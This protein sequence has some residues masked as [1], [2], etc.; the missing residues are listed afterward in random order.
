LG[1]VLAVVSGLVFRRTLFAQ[2]HDSLFVLE[3]PPY[4]MPTLRGLVT[5][6]WRHSEEFVLKAATVILAASV[7]VWVL[8]NL[9]RGVPSTE[10][11]LF[12]RA[13]GLVAPIFAPL[14]FGNWEATGSLATGL[15]AKE[16]VVSS[17]SVIYLGGEGAPAPE[18]VNLAADVKEIV[19]GFGQA[20]VDSVRIVLSIIPGVDLTSQAPVET[21]TA[22]S[23]ALQ[24]N[25]TPLSAAAFL[26]FVLLYAPCVATLAALKAEFGSRWMV[27]SF[28]YLLALAWLAGFVVYQV[29]GW[30]LGL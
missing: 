7:V 27:F 9:P 16:V 2:T 21:D 13:A 19:I 23:L 11:S 12:G 25:F 30:L 4:R 5:H 3:L 26:V 24:Q 17:M 20:V 22:L 6:M 29:G 18:P 15:V 10:D 1:I 14:G 8:L 28:F